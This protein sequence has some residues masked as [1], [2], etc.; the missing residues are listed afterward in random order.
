[1]RLKRN[2]FIFFTLIG[3][4]T[5]C[6]KD[7]YNFTQEFSIP[8]KSKEPPLIE[9]IVD[10]DNDNNILV[11]DD[12]GKVADYT[13]IPFQIKSLKELN[14]NFGISPTTRVLCV[15]ETSGLSDSVIDS[16]L[17]FVA[18]GGTLFL[19]KTT[20]DQRLG[21]LIGLQPGSNME[22]DDATYGYYLQKPIFPGLEG[23]AIA[24][25]KNAHRGLKRS[26]FS[27]KINILAT[28]ENNKEYPLII[29]NKIGKGSVILFNSNEYLFK[30][31]RGLMFAQVLMGLEG[32]PYPVANTATIFLDDYPSPVYDIDKEPIK[33]E[34]GLN[35]AE[36]VTD[37]WWPDMKQFAK[38]QNIDY[39]AYVTFDYNAF[40][41]PPFT[42]KEWDKNT[43]T[44]NNTIQKKSNWLG[45]EVYKSGHEL[46]FHG[47]NHVS[48]LQADWKQ[49]EYIVTALSAAAKK[50]KTL[51]FKE[52][53]VSYVPPSNYID[54]IG[55]AM[56]H[57]GMPSLKYI[58]STYMG[59]LEE[60]GDREFDPDPYNDNFFDYPRVSSGYVFEN[61]SLFNIE[62]MYL[63]TG[64]WTHFVHPD[65]VYQIPV[66]SNAGTSG[67][68]SYRNKYGLDW[69]THNGKKGLFDNFKD[70]IIN[71][72]KRHPMTRFLNATE[73]S[74]IVMDWRYSY[75]T[76]MR[77]DD[78]Y[79]V[80]SN[81]DL[82]KT[83]NQYW[84]M[85]VSTENEAIVRESL[86][87][88]AFNIR[89]TPF[90]DGY[91]YVV[92]TQE[93]S[94][95]VPDL[96]LKKIDTGE[97][98][99]EVLA[100]VM[101]DYNKFIEDRSILAPL[102]AQ[103]AQY[104]EEGKVKKATDL[105]ELKIKNGIHLTTG[106]WK[107]YAKYMVW[108][109]RGKEVWY[110]LQ[111][112]YS[113]NQSKEIAD[114]SRILS[115]YTEY[116][117]ED[118]R[119]K[120]LMRQI[121][122]GADEERIFI[123]YLEYFNSKDKKHR[124]LRVLK[125]LVLLNPSLPNRKRYINHLIEYNF[126]E[127]VP[128]LNKIHPC[129]TDYKDLATT[130]T[131]VYADHLNYD[132]AL[133]WGKCSEGIEEEIV[134][135]WQVNSR[136]FEDLKET[137]YPFYID[138]LIAND[139]RKA[140]KSLQKQRPCEE[141]LEHLAK[142][143]AKVYTDFGLVK[144]ALKWSKCSDDV[145]ITS[146]MSWLFEAKEYDKLNRTYVA[147]IRDHPEDYNAKLYMS[148]L[149]LQQGRV[150][151]SAKIA[152]GLPKSIDG[153]LIRAGINKQIVNLNIKDQREVLRRYDNILYSKVR[154]EITKRVRQEEGNSISI[155][156]R[157]IN[158]KFDPT[159]VFNILSYNMYDKQYN[160]HSVSITESTV[161]PISFARE[162]DINARRSL[163]GLEYRFK[164][165]S[166]KK[167]RYWGRAR[168]ERDNFN[169]VYF[170]LG[171][172]IELSKNNKFNSFQLDYYPVR[173]GPG[174]VLGIYRGVFT[175]YN[176]FL[177]S[178]KVKQIFSLEANY[179]SDAEIEG[180]ILG[181]TEYDIVKTKKLSV[182]PLLEA[183]YSQG[184]V[185]RRN[186]FPYWMAN[187]RIYG[188]G[189]LAFK[190]GTEKSAFKMTADAS[191]FAENGEPGFERYTGSFSWR[192]KDF[193]TLKANFEVYT[194]EKYYS[195]EF[196]LGLIYNFK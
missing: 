158:D 85:Y 169:K 139:P 194:I 27:E 36:Y 54:S 105:I 165:Q 6:Q 168:L 82:G 167:E 151:Y 183:G 55:L 75:F 121:E 73:S 178:K 128:E 38:E 58:Q 37:V 188:G 164:N 115:F 110:T 35:I 7:I 98:R 93:K 179:Y 84:F 171:A 108:Q 94:I 153:H 86:K 113:E 80:E 18:G 20:I 150:K 11:A 65:D 106:Q 31:F 125:R 175:N 109:K 46:G 25:K 56:L 114:L 173:T 159:A 57:K 148:G 160:I 147:Y 152:S 4:F 145:P 87:D 189:G 144:E 191:L 102:T 10:T 142:K 52:L 43:F 138:L 42:F 72:K 120:W 34:L 186:G 182:S 129:D 32:I 95:S 140:I 104:I 63:F 69:Y 117:T 64:I 136:S 96:Y 124:I 161:Y 61:N 17:D 68:F 70:E 137:N 149:L 176:E 79:T 45:R 141:Q 62:S 83:S 146:I 174:H 132:E 170:Q 53:P 162:D 59:V 9:F 123:E 44:K 67:H 21:F 50:W 122:W 97:N 60:G 39:T 91:L 40:T 92:K 8:E 177:L 29:E 26:N 126:E 163:W 19:T 111:G 49:E 100:A 127:L 47:Y 143:I 24:N 77:Y 81:F 22:E 116:P 28:A 90:L 185:D 193:T 13:K 187:R 5:S 134:N 119:E 131:W 1:M 180:I 184:S 51:D 107:D 196:R 99:F 74:E 190:M 112:Y 156:S 88:Q 118:I 71:F 192:I 41:T 130:I 12:L 30:R 181:R 89:K 166:Y 172:G 135:D 23:F 101:Q 76:H 66:P 3:L 78:K 133:A 15:Y 155:D 154:E 103:V 2:H 195:N 14:E 16:F 48:L 33:T 157:S